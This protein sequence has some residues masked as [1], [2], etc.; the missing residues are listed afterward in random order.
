V[1][2]DTQP[3]LNNGGPDAGDSVPAVR[4]P[5]RILD[6][7]CVKPFTG[8]QLCVVPDGADLDPETM[9]SLA[10]EIG[11]SETTFVT[12]IDDDGY[13]VRIFTPDQELPFAG[14]PTLGTAYLLASEGRVA[15]STTQR[16]GAGALRVEVDPDR[17]A[18]RMRQFPGA[19]APPFED[20]A[21]VAAA[22]GLEETDLHPDRPV[23]TVTTGLAHTIV[24]ARD[25]GVVRRAELRP[26]AVRDVVGRTGGESL[27]LFA[28]EGPEILA[29]M[30][31][32][33]PGIG[34]D[35][36]TGSAAG[37]LGV[38]L[39]ED[40]IAGMPG[41]ITVRQGEQVGRPS[42]LEVEVRREGKAWIAWVGGRV[43]LAGE[44]E[45]RL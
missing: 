15:S 4:V 36:A 23:R 29:R 1:R 44:G 42:R 7:F 45:F 38:Y 12:S 40:G 21:G 43:R 17:G 3:T 30:F 13:D 28:E 19:L 25:A 9:R 35:P 20:R 41:A 16:C 27:Y 39:A 8:N 10:Q 24:P 18:G 34:E 6:V 31:D 32:P 22:A 26:T 14:H 5:F 33:G 11:F 37:P 2:S